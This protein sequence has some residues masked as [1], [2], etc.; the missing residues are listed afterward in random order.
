MPAWA[1]VL[2]GVVAA[3]VYI[4]LRGVCELVKCIDNLIKLKANILK[5][6]RNENILVDDPMQAMAIHFGGGLTGLV[7]CPFLIYDGIFFK[8]DQ[9][10]AIVRCTHLVIQ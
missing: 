1:A 9:H 7:T 4:G 3:L 6:L 2:T 8:Q 10:S 5:M